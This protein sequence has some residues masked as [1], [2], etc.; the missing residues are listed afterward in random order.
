[1][2]W[3]R[4]V[5]ALVAGLALARAGAAGAQPPAG[6]PPAPSESSNP[7]AG[8]VGFF[9]GVGVGAGVMGLACGPSCDG[10]DGSAGLSGHAGFLLA[11]GLVVLYDAAL[12]AHLDD[13]PLGPV[14]V[15]HSTHLVALQG[16]VAPRVWLR[17]G[18]GLAHLRIKHVGIGSRAETVPALG[19]ALGVEVARAGPTVI[20]GVL[21]VSA[22]FFDEDDGQDGS[23][24]TVSIGA[25]ASWY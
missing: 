12:L 21:R 3:A 1:V 13:S 25:G 20:E 22:G 17:G 4:A 7:P 23:V 24:Y 11:S 10:L 16:W 2:T 5:R 9:G 15:F 14:R 19:A 6:A 18:P 8:R